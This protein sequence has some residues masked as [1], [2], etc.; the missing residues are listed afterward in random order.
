MEMNTVDTKTNEVRLQDYVR[1]TRRKL[2]NR[3]KKRQMT[4]PHLGQS[5]LRQGRSGA[6]PKGLVL[7]LPTVTSE[8]TG[9][10]A[11]WPAEF[12]IEIMVG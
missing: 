12:C 7:Q 8:W 3:T 5:R 9:C 6:R 10:A 11:S 1:E 2:L 4:A